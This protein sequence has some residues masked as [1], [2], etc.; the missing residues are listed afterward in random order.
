MT[1]TDS[2]CCQY[3]KKVEKCNRLLMQNEVRTTR[4]TAYE[5]I[6]RPPSSDRNLRLSILSELRKEAQTHQLRVG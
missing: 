5:E 4:Q 6:N 3:P 2:G 1:E